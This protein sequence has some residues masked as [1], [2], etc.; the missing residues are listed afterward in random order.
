VLAGYR[1]YAWLPRPPGPDD[2][3]VAPIVT[4][5]IDEALAAKGYRHDGRTPQFL[6]AWYATLEA[7]QRVTTVPIGYQR[8]RHPSLP[9]P[10]PPLRLVHE[11]I[12]GTL[13][14]DVLDAP[15][16]SLVWRGTAEAEVLPSTDRTTREARIREAV[17]R[18]LERFPP[19]P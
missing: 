9:S 1:A 2:A 3:A 10:T 16:K 6:V 12:D 15:T 18:I 7:G 8:Y 5:A 14:V 13:I 4:H 11:Y 17:R 19:K